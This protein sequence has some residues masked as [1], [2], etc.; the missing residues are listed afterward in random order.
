MY[1][2]VNEKL[3]SEAPI[4]APRTARIRAINGIVAYE[5]VTVDPTIKTDRVLGQ[6]AA[7]RGIQVPGANVIELRFRIV[8]T[9]G[10]LKGVGNSIAVITLQITEGI[11]AVLVIDRVPAASAGHQ[12]YDVKGVVLQVIVRAVR[13]IMSSDA[14][15]V[16]RTGIISIYS[17]CVPN[18]V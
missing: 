7:Q 13:T 4:L 1:G 3:L 6:E 17:Y 14:R 2:L 16:V 9:P 11:V 12:S 18:S 10:E 15:D 8:F 5:G